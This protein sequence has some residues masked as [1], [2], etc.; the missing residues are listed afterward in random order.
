MRVSSLVRAGVPLMALSGCALTDVTIQPTTLAGAIPPTNVGRDRVVVMETPFVDGRGSP[1]RCG[2]KKNGYGMDTA[3]IQC[4]VPPT[5]WV[6]GALTDGLQRAGFRV[7]YGASPTP[8]TPRI[9]GQVTQFFVEPKLGFFTYTPEADIGVRL[10][11]TTASGLLAQR[12]FYFKGEEALVGFGTK[13]VFEDAA[14]HAT[15]KATREMVAAIVALLDRYP[16]LGEPVA[17]PPQP[18]SMIE[19]PR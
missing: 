8:S 5:D 18:V 3:A 19:V 17:L 1:E 6:A 11:V 12:E 13:D 14:D 15:V 9:Q 7:V 2:M 10:Q 4:G 16:G